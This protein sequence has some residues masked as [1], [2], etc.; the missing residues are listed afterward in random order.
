MCGSSWEEDNKDLHKYI[1]SRTANTEDMEDTVNKFSDTL[2][3]ACNKSFKIGR[4]FMKTN[5][6][7]TVPWWIEDLTI[8]T[9]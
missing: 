5:E 3:M 8:A 1:S 2:T 6:H 9:N 4:A 7:K